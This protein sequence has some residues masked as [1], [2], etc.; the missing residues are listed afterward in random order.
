MTFIYETYNTVSQ[1]GFI[2][3]REN[4]P[5]YITQN[6]KYPLRPYQEEAI[7]RYLYYKTDKNRAVP[8]Q[9]LYNMATGS[10]KTLLMAAVILEKYK[11]GERNFIFFVNNDNILTKTRDNFLE[12][13]S[14]KYLFTE[15]IVIDNQNV[16]IRE[17]T[18]FSDSRDDSINIVFTTIQKLHLDLNTPRENR[19]SY[20][21]FKDISVV[22]LADEAH[23]L[24]AGLSKSEKDDN[25]SWT[26]TIETIQKT[27]QKSSIFEFTATIDLSNPTLAQKYEKSLLFKYDLKEFRLDKYSKDVLFHLVDGSVNNR[28][29]QA[30][31]ISQFRKKIALKNGINLKPLVMFKSQ[32]ISESEGN[33]HSFLELLNRLTVEDIQNQRTLVSETE[34]QNNILKKALE[35]FESAGI[36]DTDLISELQED[37][38]QERLLLVDGKNKNKNSLSLLNTLEQ[39]EN[40]IRAIFAVDMLNEG[41]DVLNL[42]DIVRLYDIRD[43]KTTKTGFVAG[44]TTNTEKQLIGRGA[45]YYPFVI[46]N[47]VEEKYTRKFDENENNELRVIEQLHYHSANN[48]RYISEL[49]QVLRESGIYDDQELEER[50]LKLKESFKK[51]RTYTDG[52][53]W[54]NKRLSY[55]ELAEG[56]Q[57]SLFDTSFIPKSF[58]VVLPSQGVHDIDAFDESLY[59]SEPLA[60]VSFKFGR[61]IGNNIVRAAINRNKNFTFDNLQKAFLGLGSVSGFITMLSDIDVRVESQHKLVSDLTQADKLYITEQLLHHIEKDL[62]SKEERFFGSDTFEKYQIKDLFEDNILRKYTIKKNS[63]AEFGLSQKNPAETNYYE[64][65]DSFD[66]YAY[67]DNFGTD[68]EKLL[69]RLLKDLMS[70]LEEKWTDIYLLRNEK[71]VRIYSFEKGKPF[72]PDFLMFANDKKT[73]NV[74]W[75]IFIE[76]KG[77]Q[78]LDSENTFKNGKEGWKE[79]FLRQISE[80]DEVRTLVDNDR[81]RIVGLPFFNEMVSKDEVKEKLRTL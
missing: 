10:G 22:M 3:F 21:Q 5:S 35:Y 37:F 74:S 78:F 73:G 15:K 32:K 77:S 46:G 79:E 56:R 2:D 66:W 31:L 24:N 28:M 71:A 70:E 23:H 72:E 33:L 44:K 59:I 80:R 67:D 38:R 52:V 55:Q 60:S 36:S 54:M 41:W 29:L 1:S 7:G 49:K 61:E 16:N 43:G 76:P 63:Q 62:I 47:N 25:T 42:F 19:L 34:E 53:V 51:T 39:P 57:E 11:Q 20:E 9:I 4:I 50:Q 8:E 13:S 40:E 81:Y 69:V 14:G 75:Q 12:N 27:A 68:E 45:R 65:L 48:P 30:I 6:L 17:V 26:N 58:E 64:D 18:D